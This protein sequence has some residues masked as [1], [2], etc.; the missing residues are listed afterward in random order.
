MTTAPG[1]NVSVTA[2]TR[3]T[4]RVCGTARSVR[5]RPWA[6]A[7]RG[8]ESKAASGTVTRGVAESV[9]RV[10]MLTD[11]P[12]GRPPRGTE[13]DGYGVGAYQMGEVQA[14]SWMTGGRTGLGVTP[15][16]TASQVDQRQLGFS[17]T[18]T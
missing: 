14:R 15:T 16:R 6:A 18:R 10:P 4:S 9:G 1:T 3:Q 8:G 11:P 7:P 13:A 5:A 17:S 12:P 2:V